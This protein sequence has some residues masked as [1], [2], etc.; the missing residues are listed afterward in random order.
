[1]LVKNSCVSS[2]GMFSCS[3]RLPC[4]AQIGLLLA[5][6]QSAEGLRRVKPHSRPQ[7]ALERLQERAHGSPNE[8]VAESN[9]GPNIHTSSR[10]SS[11]LDQS[12]QRKDGKIS[13]KGSVEEMTR[14]SQGLAEAFPTSLWR[15][16]SSPGFEM[17]VVLDI[18]A[19]LVWDGVT[20]NCGGPHKVNVYYPKGASGPVPLISYAHGFTNGGD[21]L[22]EDNRARFF[23]P[24]V[25]EGFFVIAYQHG[26]TA[27]YCAANTMQLGAIEW[28]K[29]SSYA[30][31]INF[32]RV[33]LLGFS[34]GGKATWKSTTAGHP[35]VKAAVT[36][37]AHCTSDCPAPQVPTLMITGNLDSVAQQWEQKKMFD[38]MS[39]PGISADF[40]MEH[41]FDDEWVRLALEPL[42][43]S[44]F[45]CHL[46]DDQERCLE[47]NQRGQPGPLEDICFGTT[48]WIN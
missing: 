28:L 19:D 30:S 22:D 33:G 6:L 23:Q 48:S 37:N 15:N 1:V 14:C 10:D 47:L 17:E 5:S 43:M 4:F 39:V 42:F 11:L 29:T 24:L 3:M 26:G 40:E 46:L 34:M 38:R 7:T 44:M 12:L 25:E 18:P 41:S 2:V 36:V 13:S 31:M 9:A 32:D 27:L 8:R 45:R 35:G 16:R 21:V 20:N